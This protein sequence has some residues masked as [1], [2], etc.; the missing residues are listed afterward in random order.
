[1]KFDIAY[2]SLC[3]I[4]WPTRP[5][6]ASGLVNFTYSAAPIAYE[7]SGP[8]AYTIAS[9][10]CWFIKYWDLGQIITSGQGVV[11]YCMRYYF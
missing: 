5:Y 10:S 6:I 9:N 3:T 2:F 11:R 8:R 4:S 1:M 7:L